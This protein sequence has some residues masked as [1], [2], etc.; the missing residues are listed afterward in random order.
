MS[1][2]VATHL[3]LQQTQ[4]QQRAVRKG[5]GSGLGV[6]SQVEEELESQDAPLPAST[7]TANGQEDTL[8]IKV[9]GLV[10]SASWGMGRSS[11]DRQYFFINGRPVDAKSLQKA[12]NEVYKGF[13]T[14]QVPLAVFDFLI[15]RGEFVF[16]P[17]SSSSVQGTHDTS[18]SCSACTCPSSPLTRQNQS[19]STSPRTNG[20]SSFT[21]NKISLSPS[22]KRSRR[23]SHPVGA[24]LL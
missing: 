16:P 4:T 18:L 6:G 8:K 7:N 21:Q 3:Q 14:H 24:I 12:L 2:G 20:Q 11:A 10:S 1:R 13:N 23:S 9:K 19:I 22:A 15:P 17:R 5:S